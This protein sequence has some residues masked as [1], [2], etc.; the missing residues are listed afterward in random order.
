MALVTYKR[1]A[2]FD[3]VDWNLN[4]LF[5]SLL[6]K[7]CSVKTSGNYPKANIIGKENSYLIALD[8][9]GIS[10]DEI[11]LAF[12]DNV[13]TISGERKNEKNEDKETYISREVSYGKFS[14]SFTLPE[15]VDTEKIDAQ[16]KDGVLEVTVPK[17]E[18]QIQK[19]I[20]IKIK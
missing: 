13:L 4:S 10:K 12:K 20:E 8:V 2:D 15:G 16:F 19:E 11:S 6:G 7:D 17:P 3:F 14:R 5:D 1:P 18:K 9:P